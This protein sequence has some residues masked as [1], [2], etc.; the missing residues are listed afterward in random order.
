[1]VK[2]R[3][4]VVT[5]VV[6]I[7]LALLFGF[8]LNHGGVLTWKDFPGV[9][10]GVDVAYNDLGATKKLVDEVASYTNLIIIGNTGITWNATKLDEDCQYIYGKGL[11]FIVFTHSVPDKAIMNQSLWTE[12]ARKKWG[13]H[14][15]GVYI[16]DE[17]G[18]RQLDCDP[19]MFITQAS[20]YSDAS[21]KYVGNLTLMLENSKQ[22]LNTGSLPIFTSDYAL[23]WF[24]Y[25]AGYD[26][27]LTEFGLN[28]SWQQ[29]VDSRQLNVA[30]CRGAAT[31]HN[32][33]WGVIVTWTYD[34][35]PYIESGDELYE[36]MIAAYV[37]GAKYILVFDSD[38]NYKSE[39]LERQHFEAMEKF[40]SYI[41]AHPRGTESTNDR[42]AY[43][44]P[45]DYGYGFRGLNDKIWGLWPAD[46]LTDQ[47]CNN[48]NSLMIQYT[49]SVD[50]VYLDGSD[51]FHES[52]Y[53]KVVFWNGTEMS[54]T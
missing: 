37:N 5:V 21:Q 13:E 47:I 7:A 18:G 29:N 8:F 48:L 27:V 22:D 16:Y 10:V 40:W 52:V 32:K 26:V 39:I 49:T 11:N 36:D 33:D 19:D 9:Y 45:T 35:P 17:T 42:V 41:N 25:E 6:L 50:I 30:L 34:K 1:M 28:S 4:L 43:V 3:L 20:N 46:S 15:L 51:L 54:L 2:N 31:A 44:L 23:Y 53:N 12:N 14:F 38:E 24:D